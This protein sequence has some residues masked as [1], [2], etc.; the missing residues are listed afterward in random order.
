MLSDVDWSQPIPWIV[1]LGGLLILLVV[2][3]LFSLGRHLGKVDDLAFALHE[4]LTA[5]EAEIAK[6]KAECVRRLPGQRL[7]TTDM[8]AVK[9]IADT[10]FYGRHAHKG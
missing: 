2:W 8:V 7:P 9:P 3:E 5:A 1:V 6:L 4:D 10:Q